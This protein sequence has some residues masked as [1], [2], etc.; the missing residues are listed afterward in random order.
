[1]LEQIST[2]QSY[3]IRIPFREASPCLESQADTLKIKRRRQ[4]STLRCQSPAQVWWVI[5]TAGPLELRARN[6]LPTEQGASVLAARP[7]SRRLSHQMAI[8]LVNQNTHSNGR[9]YPQ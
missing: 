5:L 4:P 6:P 1:M 2:I 3:Q 8:W 7:L 9:S